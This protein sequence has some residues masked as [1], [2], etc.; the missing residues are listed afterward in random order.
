MEDTSK[1][2]VVLD[3]FY[4]HEKI[5]FF[6][7]RSTVL[8]FFFFLKCGDESFVFTSFYSTALKVKVKKS[9]SEF[10]M[11]ILELR[12]DP[13]EPCRYFPVCVGQFEGL[14][15]Q[16]TPCVPRDR[17]VDGFVQRGLQILTQE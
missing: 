4:F 2:V 9:Q 16:L 12:F 5:K 8:S 13:V 15:P 11:K 6:S 7:F 3:S 17:T 1:E 10:N 14:F